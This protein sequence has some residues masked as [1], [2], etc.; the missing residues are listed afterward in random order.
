MKR[1]PAVAFVFVFL[2]TAL[3]AVPPKSAVTPVPDFWYVVAG[4]APPTSADASLVVQGIVIPSSVRPTVQTTPKGSIIA[5]DRPDGTRQSFVIQGMS[6][7]T[8]EPGPL[9][10]TTYA[11]FPELIVDPPR[12]SS[13][14]TCATWFN[15]EE[16]LEALSCVTGCNGCFCE[17]CICSPRWP[18]PIA[19]RDVMTLVA[20]NDRAN[21]MTF[22]KV[23]GAWNLA[24]GSR[25]TP[26]VHFRGRSLEATMGEEGETEIRGVQSISL[27]GA[28]LQRSHVTAD[29]A[30]FAWS[31][32]SG[33]IIF[34]QPKSMAAPVY[35]D[36]TI[37]FGPHSGSAQASLRPYLE[38]APLMD[39]CQVCGTHPNSVADVE[40]LKCVPGDS[41]CYR[42]ISWTC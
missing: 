13:C 27:P 22:A 23:D 37:E 42:C 36:G 16:S 28:I 29:K 12:E 10:N 30:F 18:C 11:R 2:V 24:M 41:T 9:A 1:L 38:V 17:G 26:P 14:C 15:A 4:E 35:R 34:E 40:R 8:F 21:T 20:N 19:P 25:G 33:S 6:K 32:P 3:H 31:S 7:F 39:S 5:W